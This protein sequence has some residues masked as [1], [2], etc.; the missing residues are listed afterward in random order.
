M[1]DFYEF[2]SCY[3]NNTVVV[4]AAAKYIKDDMANIPALTPVC[5]FQ[6]VAA[7]LAPFI[8]IKTEYAVGQIVFTAYLNSIVKSDRSSPLSILFS[9]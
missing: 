3:I 1:D 7:L 2:F 6:V 8:I 4:I 9:D 5:H